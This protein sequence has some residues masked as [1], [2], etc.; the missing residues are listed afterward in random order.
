[1][2]LLLL[3]PTFFVFLSSKCFA[4]MNLKSFQT[5]PKLVITLVIDQFRSDYLTRFQNEFLPQQKTNGEIGG[6][7]FL[8][9]ES[10][11]FPFASYDVFQNVTCPG[12]AMIS[13]GSR[14]YVNGIVM[15]NYFDRLKNKMVYCVDDDKDEFSPRQLKSTTF[16]D[17]YKN[18][19]LPAKVIAL[20]L[21]DRSAIMLGGHRADYT[22]WMDYKNY[23]WGTSSYYTKKTPEWFNRYN[24]NLKKLE[25]KEIQVLNKKVKLLSKTGLSFVDGVDQTFSLAEEVIKQEKLGLN[26][27]TDFLMISIS[28]HDML[29]HQLGMH[30]AEMQQLTLFEDQRL[31]QFLNRLKKHLKNFD[32]VQIVLTADHGVSPTT[33]YLKEAKFDSG[34]IDYLEVY[35]KINQALDKKYGQVKNKN[36]IIGSK[37]LQLYFDQELITSKKIPYEEMSQVAFEALKDL[38]GAEV[39]LK[40]SDLLKNKYP[41]GLL[42]EQIKHQFDADKSGDIIIIAKP[43]YYDKTDNLTTHITG[44]SYDRTVPLLFFGKKFKKGVYSEQA[45]VIDLAPTLS[46]SLGVTAPSLSEGKVLPIFK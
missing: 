23:R 34:Q 42:G 26:Q 14:P 27:Q 11:F 35:K 3:I 16:S 39:I 21:K 4:Q 28:T 37:A 8:M 43:F 32:D 30:S 45:L 25:N 24:E 7:Q 17:E 2:K 12:H 13:T 10:A 41:T 36:W 5:K 18:A 15:N 22:F 29:G 46:F 9:N 38:K 44:Y 31:S 19:G 40:R 1:M 20:A 33:D 6:F